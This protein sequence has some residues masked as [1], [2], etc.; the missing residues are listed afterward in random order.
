ME[1]TSESLNKVYEVEKIITCKICKNQKYYLIKWLCY[2]I[3]ESTWEPKSS[4]KHLKEMLRKFEVNY[5]NS[6][7]QNMYKIYCNE[8]KQRKQTN[9]KGQVK[10]EDKNRIKPL[11]KTKK[12]E[13]FTKAE[14][15]D[16]CY[17][18]LKSHFFIDVIK[19]NMGK[20]EGQVIIELSS[21]SSTSISEE[22]ISIVLSEKE[23]LREKE[24]EKDE[25]KLSMPI[26]E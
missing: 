14:L 21:S 12:I 13:G 18:K 22:N 8:M 4:I 15:K 9:K 7:D 16:I 26:L 6:I 24:E 5:P 3:T 11:S 23:D 1:N 2:P 10:K 25:N 17:E 20:T 19:R